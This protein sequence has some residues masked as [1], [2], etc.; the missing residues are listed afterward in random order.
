MEKIKNNINAAMARTKA[1]L[2][3]KNASIINVFTQ[4]I[5][6]NDIAI[7]KYT[8]IGI[9]KYDGICEI[10]CSELFVAPGFIDAHVHIESSMVTPEIFS[11]LVIKRGVTSIIADPHEIANV[12]GEEGI[13]FMLQNSAK[14]TIDTFIMLP[15]CVPALEF[16]DNGAVLKADVLSRFID[17]QKVLGLG[18]VMDVNAVTACN[19]SMLQKI[20]MTCKSHK[21]IDG[22]CPKVSISE[23]NAY[24]CAGICTDHECSDVDE[25]LEKVRLGMHV[26][27]REGSA[28]RNLIDLLPAVDDKNYNRFLFCTDDRHIE[29]I[30]DEGSIDNCIRIAIREG[31]DPIKAYTIASYNAANCYNLRDRGAIAPGFK[32]DLVIFKDI[33]KL[34]IKDVIKN[35]EIYR[36]KET[37]SKV[38]SKKSVKLD[39]IKKDLF[40]IEA[41]GKEVNVIKVKPGSLETTKEKRKISVENRLIKKVVQAEEVI[42]KIAVI[43]RHKNTEKHS[44]GFIE[45]LGLRGAAIAQTIAHDSHNIIVIGDND[46]DME[47][48][49]NSIISKDGGIVIVSN[50]KLLDF[51]S[52]PIGGLMTCESPEIV[53]DKISKLNLL[54]RKYGVKNEV[55]PFLTL[56]FMALP[57]IPYLKI[58]DRGLFDSSSYSFIDLFEI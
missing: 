57:V 10:D 26:L 55:D 8:I 28:A 42:N 31:L 46:K 12:L 13:E 53:I 4:K 30:M 14:G 41:K 21:N 6:I 58:T 34:I 39:F 33:N 22:H 5:E 15:S 43:E 44:V 16:E 52:L 19:E 25:A 37:Y 27:L 7:N 35:G 40:H 38:T 54:A 56:A 20:L 11:N 29:N 1:A 24:L 47:I 48:A 45:G 49:V 2:V 3:L 32:A 18:E 23:L 36:N 17:N 50:G 9:G 51:L